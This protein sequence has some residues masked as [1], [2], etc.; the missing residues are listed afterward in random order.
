MSNEMSSQP[1][2]FLSYAHDDRAKA[3]RLA[4]ALE[5]AGYIVWWDALIEGGAQFAK[6]IREALGSGRR[7]GRPVVEEFDRIRLGA[8]RG[9]AGPRPPAAGAAVAR[10][11]RCRRSVFANIR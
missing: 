3:Q 6:S 7:G 1:T 11:Q 10:R 2:V 4:A 9:G 8:G 5:R